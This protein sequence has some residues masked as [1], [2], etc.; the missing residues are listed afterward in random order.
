MSRSDKTPVQP[1]SAFSEVVGSDC[2]T[3]PKWNRDACQATRV[4]YGESRFYRHDEGGNISFRKGATFLAGKISGFVGDDR[5]LDSWRKAQAKKLGSNELVEE[6]VQ[7]MA[8][9]GTEE[10][11][12]YDLLIKGELTEAALVV[13]MQAF[14]EKSDLSELATHMAIER[15]KRDV[16]AF[17]QFNIEHNVEC[18]ATE[19]MVTSSTL[20]TS[21]PI[22]IVC[23]GQFSNGKG[24]KRE[25][26]WAW[27]NL[28]SSENEQ[29]HR[30]Q[31]AVER[32]L[33]FETI[34]KQCKEIEDLPILILTVRPKNWRD[35]PS[36]DL[37]D[38]TEFATSD[39]AINT[40]KTAAQLA[41]ASG[42]FKTPDVSSLTWE[43]PMTNDTKFTF[44][45]M[46]I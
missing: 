31:C 32:Q 25:K 3:S 33:G 28:K 8:D 23:T 40:I 19:Q 13:A 11:I 12:A 14:A 39:Y 46:F 18:Y 37:K 27:V 44:N 17:R 43:G 10:H 4:Q 26:C 1:V 6:W 24:K 29:N 38:Y 9:F 34:W 20:V 42:L 30:W 16:L 45:P 7:N 15:A 22:D 35:E 2:Y 41:K 36:F 5:Y 21:T